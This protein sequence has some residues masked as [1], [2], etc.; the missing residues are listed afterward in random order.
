M[1][2]EHRQVQAGPGPG[3]CMRPGSWAH[4]DLAREAACCSTAHLVARLDAT[5]TCAAPS[6]PRAFFAGEP[7]ASRSGMPGGAP[8]GR[9]R[10]LAGRAAFSAV[11]S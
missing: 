1:L 6:G 2:D 10:Y 3:A 11:V 8:R 9:Y 4:A 5:S 7:A